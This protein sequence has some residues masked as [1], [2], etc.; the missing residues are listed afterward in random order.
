MGAMQASDK[1]KARKRGS[2]NDAIKY[3]ERNGAARL[4]DVRDYVKAVYEV[5]PEVGLDPSIVIAQSVHETTDGGA[6]WNSFWWRTRLNPAGLGITGNSAENNA[7]RTWT[8][9]RD[10][11]IS[12]VAHMYLYAVGDLEDAPAPLSPDVDPRYDAFMDAFTPGFAR[13][14]SSLT[15]TWAADPNYATKI[16]ARGNA[17]FPNIAAAPTSSTGVPAALNMTKGIIPLP[18]MIDHIIDVSLRCQGENDDRG[19]DN[20]G[21]RTVRGCVLHRSQGTWNSNISHFDSFCPGALTDLQVDHT[22]GRMMRFVRLARPTQAVQAPS[23]WA[24]GVVFRDTNGYGDGRAFVARYG[25]RGVNRDLESC[26]ITGFFK[27]PGSNITADDPVSNATWGT[28]AQWIASRAHDYGVAWTD[29]PFVVAEGG[30]SFVIW[31]QEFTLP[32]F[33]L[34][35][36]RKVCPGRVVIDGTEALI[37]RIK[38]I[39]RRAQTGEVTFMKFDATRTFHA[40][41]GAVG[42]AGPT[43]EEPVERSFTA[44]EAISSDGF[45]IGQ[46]V[47]GDDRWLK[48][49]GENTVFVHSSGVTE[50]I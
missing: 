18:P 1:L 49:N 22:D 32:E 11:A 42:R 15:G 48:S 12:H 30:R 47:L 46:F 31:H 3:A 17:I 8:N 34:T 14:I 44:G 19:F 9:G 20:L 27:Q 50:E 33:S 6:P 7:S 28:L 16:A 24:N 4:D 23:G 29:F 13:T 41:A 25:L 40:V 35:T 43:R 39:L 21:P 26:E 2:A 38:E 45:T 10:A 5:A 37:A 36:T